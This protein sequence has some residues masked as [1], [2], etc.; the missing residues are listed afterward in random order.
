MNKIKTLMKTMQAKV[1]LS[2]V[3]LVAALTWFNTAHADTPTTVT[4]D[5][6]ATMSVSTDADGTLIVQQ[7]GEVL[8]ME[9][10]THPTDDTKGRF[11][12]LW[13]KARE[14]VHTFKTKYKDYVASKEASGNELPIESVE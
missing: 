8:L 3:V 10:D 9:G 1:A 5:N 6:P 14:Q 4:P 2:F 12:I 11:V 13:D 7:G